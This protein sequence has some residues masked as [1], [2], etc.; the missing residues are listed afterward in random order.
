MTTKKY[1]LTTVNIHIDLL[2]SHKKMTGLFATEEVFFPSHSESGLVMAEP[3]TQQ[4]PLGPTACTCKTAGHGM[5][6]LAGPQRN[7]TLAWCSNQ[8]TK[9]LLFERSNSL[10]FGRAQRPKKRWNIILLELCISLS[11]PLS[12]TCLSA[13]VLTLFVYRDIYN[14]NIIN[15]NNI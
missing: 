7:Q 12:L 1:Y 6:W 14:I 2:C 5:E 3:K 13:C 9:N 15:N 4:V 10:H 11:L 8:L